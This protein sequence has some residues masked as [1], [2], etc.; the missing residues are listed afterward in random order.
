[1]K[2][3]L[4][5]GNHP[6]H[7]FVAQAVKQTGLLGGLILQRRELM[8]PQ[9]PPGLSAATE[10][11]FLRHFAARAASEAKFFRS[12][13]PD[14]IPTLELSREN[15]NGE[16]ARAFL[17]GSKPDL[18]LVYGVH[19]LSPDL[20]ACTS[21]RQW[22]IHGGLSPWYRGSTT[23]FWPSYMLEPQ[24]TGMTV[25][26]ITQAVDG[27]RIIHQLAAPLVAGDGLHD[28]ACRTLAAFCENSRS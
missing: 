20:L 15:L 26:E 16:E 7:L 23:H 2:I 19:L 13:T 14:G 25:H 18:L 21:G 6:R 5:T 3:V 22:N 27:G 8:E 10:R 11:L 28:L 24:M 4:M 17:L 1:M 9:P 12:P